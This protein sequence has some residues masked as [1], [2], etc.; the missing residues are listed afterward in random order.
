SV[1][2]EFKGKKV[3]VFKFKKRKG[4]RQKYGYRQGFFL[5]R[6]DDVVKVS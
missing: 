4:Y 2:R 6:I 3:I 5:L 1:Q